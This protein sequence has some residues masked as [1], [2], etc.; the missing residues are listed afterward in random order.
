MTDL[1]GERSQNNS[2]VKHFKGLYLY[3]SGVKRQVISV[4]SRFGFCSS[5]PSIAGSITVEEVDDLGHPFD[6][7]IASGTAPA[8]QVADNDIEDLDPDWLDDARADDVSDHGSEVADQDLQE[9][10]P[11]EQYSDHPATSEQPGESMKQ[12]SKKAPET[13]THNSDAIEDTS[14]APASASKPRAPD[15]FGHHLLRRGAGLLRRLCHFCRVSARRNARELL[16]GNVYDNINWMEH[17]AEQRVD[18]KDTQQNGTCATIFPLFDAKPEAMRT[19]ELLKSLDSAP[20]LCIEDI[21]HS[22]AEVTLFQKSLE[23]TFL[24]QLL[25]AS[26]PLARRFQDQVDE[27]LPD[28]EDQIPLHKTEVIPLPAM[29]IDE[30]SITGNAD[31][32]DE[33]F[34]E[35]GFDPHSEDF[36]ATVRLIFGDQLSIARLRTLINNRAGHETEADSYAYTAFGPGLFHHQLAFGHGFVETHFG[37]P[38]TN[39][40]GNPS[41]L[42]F[43]NGVLDRK[44]ISPNS[45]PPYRTTRDL[46]YHILIAAT[47]ICLQ[48]VS[49]TQDFENYTATVSFD[50]LRGDVSKV[51]QKILNARVIS[52]LRRARQDEV[53]ERTRAAPD[54][55]AFD[56]FAEDQPKLKTGDM[57]FENMVLMLRDALI[58][59][60]FNDAIK[61]GYSGRICHV[62]KVLALMYRGL[63]R[64]KYAHETLHIIHNLTH[65]WPKPLRYVVLPVRYVPALTSRLSSDI[66]VKNWLVNPTGKPNSWVPVDLMQEH[67]NFWTK[68]R[69]SASFRARATYLLLSDNLQ[70]PGQ[71][72]K[73]AMAQDGYPVHL[74][75][76]EYRPTGQH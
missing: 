25:S 36:A 2:L 9:F 64:T 55:Q 53:A 48:E 54:P 65:I 1:L 43:L 33:M 73:L 14:E 3:A 47:P 39:G 23:H 70:G 67:N 66:M 40:A 34:T 72:R 38:T 58:L 19:T 29:Q 75:S 74:A 69:F 59:R 21:L 51:F 20:P 71:Q 16:C 61:G 27:C 37:D 4:F 6:N 17:V 13:R 10:A 49:G 26:E 5:Y 46:V 31:V 35:L 52:G 41:C 50:Q 24:R 56:P 18:H 60:E 68:V 22:P 32:M 76:P 15:T 63:G 62:L 8:M 28:Q 57:V 7:P 11:V 42:A 30:S 12:A 44:A 45:L